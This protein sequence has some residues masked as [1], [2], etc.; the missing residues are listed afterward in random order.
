MKL[1]RLKKHIAIMLVLSMV[2]IISGCD[3]KSETV[4][5][6]DLRTAMEAADDS[7]G[8][9]MSADSSADDAAD[10]FTYIS[11]MD[12]DKV[13]KFFVSYS[14]EGTADEIA[15]IAVKDNADINEATKS[16]DA[17]VQKRIGVFKQYAPDQVKKAEGA[18]VFS[19]E[20]YAV[21]IISDKQNAVK[22]AFEEFIAK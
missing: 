15:V 3:S 16:L 19:R 20:Q 9:M 4:S 10:L 17:H 12:Y 18:L 22:K 6:Y 8:E 14:N 13:D 2:F 11:D 5:M 21:L 7:L 1:N